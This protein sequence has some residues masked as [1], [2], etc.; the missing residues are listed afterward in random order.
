VKHDGDFG[1]PKAST[2]AVKPVQEP[3]KDSRIGCGE[4]RTGLASW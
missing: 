1:G 3:G 4:V 2:V